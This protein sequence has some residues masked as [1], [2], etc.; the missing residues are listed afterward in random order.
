MTR[1]LLF[2]VF[3]N[4]AC[5]L[6][7]AFMY[8]IDLARRGHAVR[9]ILEGDA[10]Q[11]LRVREGRFAAL[12]DEARALGLLEG[13]CRTAAS[14]CAEP[15]RDV[16]ALAQDAGLPLLDSM[17]GHAGIGSFVDDG[18]EVIVF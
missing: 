6:N 9:L 18:Y 8:A 7:H 12:F 14:G 15:S 5:R 17:R 2:A 4:D 1:K 16:L 11:S 10:T 13:V 3:T